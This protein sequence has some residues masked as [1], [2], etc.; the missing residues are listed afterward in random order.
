MWVL[1]VAG[2]GGAAAGVGGQAAAEHAARPGRC[3]ALQ[4]AIVDCST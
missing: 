2:P 1:H 3:A 4:T